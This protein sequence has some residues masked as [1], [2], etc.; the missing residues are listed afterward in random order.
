MKQITAIFGILL[1]AV[2]L[3]FG[4]LLTS[5]AWHT[6][7]VTS[8]ALGIEIILMIVVSCIRLKDA[9]RASFNVLFP[10]LA[11][12]QFIV[13]LFVPQDGGDSACYIIAAVIALVQILLL[14]AANA[15][16]KHN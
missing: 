5:Y 4:Y 14:L 15:V 2:N 10:L 9:F 3:L 16:S 1:I 7:V 13:L 11:I 6:A 12:I 8:V